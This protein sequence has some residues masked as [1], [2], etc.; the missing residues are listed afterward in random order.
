M[1]IVSIV[2]NLHEMP[3]PSFWKS[4]KYYFRISFAENFTQSV[5]R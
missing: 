1:Q 4:K 2:D 3:N 5:E